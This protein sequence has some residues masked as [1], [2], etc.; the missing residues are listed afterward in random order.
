MYGK[1]EITPIILSTLRVAIKRYPEVVPM[2]IGYGRWMAYAWADNGI[3]IKSYDDFLSR[4]KGLIRGVYSGKIGGAFIDSMAALVS[5][6]IT[7]AVRQ[8]WRD[9]GDEGKIP[10]YLTEY[11]DSLILDQ[12]D[13]V[14]QFYRDIVDAKLE[15][16]PLDG[17]YSRAEIW[18][19]Q[20]N[21]AYNEAV[22]LITLDT[23]GKLE[24]EYGDTDHCDTCLSLNGIV[25][26]AREWDEL[27]VHPQQPKNDMLECGGWKCQCRLVPTEARRSP[28]A[29]NLIL[30]AVTKL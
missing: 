28:K 15:K 29:Y 10:P 26:F 18:A 14:D 23:G 17:L 13:F 1:A 6:Q 3:E 27:G 22:R 21:S 12:Y 4:I 19:N 25:A 16:L 20:F 11:S 2:L 8:A 7:L 5:R 24:W 9:E 30:N